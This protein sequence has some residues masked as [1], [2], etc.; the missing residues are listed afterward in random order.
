VSGVLAVL[1]VWMTGVLILSLSRP[2]ASW[3]Q[4]VVEVPTAFGLGAGSLYLLFLWIGL[5]KTGGVVWFYLPLTVLLIAQCRAKRG[6]A[7]G[8]GG[9][10]SPWRP[11]EYLLFFTLLAVLL[12]SAALSLALPLLDWDT[13][14]LWALKAKLL[15]SEPTLAS[16]VFRDPYRLHIHPRYPLLLPWLGAFMA[17]HQ[18]EFQE[19][20]Y[21]L[22]SCLFSALAIWQ[23]YRL[24]RPAS[25]RI[26]ALVLCLTL[27]CSGVW[28]QAV[29]GSS[30]EVA[31]CFFLL[32]ALGS[33][34]RWLEERAYRELMTAGFFLYCLAMTKN[35]GLLLALCLLVGLVVGLLLEREFAS[36]P[37]AVGLPVTIFLVA[38]AV[39]FWH[40]SKIPPVSDENYLQRLHPDSLRQGVGRLGV[41]LKTA[42]AEATDL[43]RWHLT[44]MLPFV[45]PFLA[46][47]R[48]L[49]RPCFV[50]PCLLG[51]GY[52]LGVLFVYLV[53]PWRD[54]SMHVGVTF[55]RVMLPMLPVLL[56][57][58][59]K[60]L[61]A[62]S[63]AK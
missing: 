12:G 1:P 57:L 7:A 26:E 2:T 34:L 43:H 53:S 5:P 14:I 20:H 27:A 13:R 25:S 46:G 6:G 62:K 32:L 15:A 23:F 11:V 44:W 22:L 24:L 50:L 61:A 21:Q 10:V 36:M 28:L 33:L 35:E 8:G 39:W 59:G 47:W 16:E 4:L 56:L 51:L 3:R 19:I 30:V 55:D 9:L 38:S 37:A 48:R 63:E 54:I 17:W 18:G 40:L 60:V 49:R 41:I 29:F 58:V 31:L 42:V 45:L 52:P